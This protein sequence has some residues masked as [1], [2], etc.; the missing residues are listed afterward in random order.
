MLGIKYRPEIDGLRALAIIPVVLFHADIS[1]FNGGYIGVSM[2]FVISGY[3]I[4]SLIKRDID[5][6]QFSF[7]EFWERRA[8]R[9][10][11]ALFTVMLVTLI[12]A[13]FYELPG[14]FK[15]LGDSALA[16]SFFASNM[17]FWQQAGYFDAASD[18]KALLHTWSLSVEEQFYLLFPGFLFLISKHGKP[19]RKHLIVV[20]LIMSLVVSAWSVT[21]YPTATFYLLP[22]RA[23][24]LLL[25]AWIACMQPNERVSVRVR[26]TISWLALIIIIIAVFMFDND[27]KFPGLSALVPCGTTAMIIWAN[28]GYLTRVGKILSHRLLVGIGLISYSLYLWHWPILVLADY[29][30]TDRLSGLVKFGLIMISTLLAW[31]SWK[32]IETPV[33]RR[34]VFNTRYRITTASLATGSVIALA[35]LLI[36]YT[37]GFPKRM[38]PEVMQMAMEA[39]EPPRTDP[40]VKMTSTM[41]KNDELCK[42]NAVDAEPELLVWGDSHAYALKPLIEEMSGE[43]QVPTWF[44]SAMGCLAVIG[45]NTGTNQDCHNFNSAMLDVVKRHHV[46]NVLL[47]SRWAKYVHG[48]EKRGEWKMLIE[49]AG[50]KHGTSD[51]AKT[52]FND[53]MMQTIKQL[54]GAGA[55]VWIMKQ[56]P[57]Q[58]F[59]VLHRLISIIRNGEDAKTIGEPIDVHLARQK[60][61][62]S[63]LDKTQE[64]GV[65]LIDPA[66]IM[67]Q[68]KGFCRAEYNGHSLYRDNDH[69]SSYGA[70]HLKPLFINMF[71]TISGQDI[72]P[73]P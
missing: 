51:D 69:I 36:H 64:S 6:G 10:L 46:R 52:L 49:D 1:G 59:K 15:S 39:A 23:W 73:S 3:L 33:R 54:Q 26:E 17:Y 13:W 14:D 21:P 32:F 25:G 44:A 56:V 57:F 53:H 42:F 2:F 22:T 62:N 43:Y 65:H 38:S 19:F 70:L 28:T 29:T 24:E 72:Q 40:C 37:D 34:R 5:A 48:Y 16:Q 50:K 18:T 7:L 8:R 27:T 66:Q 41:V 35:G 31:L 9:I 71:A 68:E 30:S 20:L 11:P 67:C 60:F 4:T 55:N 63:V 45:I 58:N 12:V 47:V 61:V